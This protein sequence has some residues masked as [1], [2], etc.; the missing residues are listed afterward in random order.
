[1]RKG[2][3]E[4]VDSIDDDIFDFEF[5]DL[6]GADSEGPNEESASEDEVIELVDVVEEG[7]VL[8]D[9]DEDSELDDL[10]ITMESGEIREDEADDL[11]IAMES[12]NLFDETSDDDSE[13]LITAMESDDFL[14][15][16][17]EEEPELTIDDDST[18][19][20]SLEG[21][22]LSEEPE[23]DL[24]ES[25][26]E[27]LAEVE[28]NEDSILKLEDLVEPEDIEVVEADQEDDR[29]EEEDSSLSFGF[30]SRC[31]P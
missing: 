4:E 29:L 26:L 23:L 16:L 31:P 25:D 5:D 20:T 30:R 7:D 28:G 1:M 12:G 9:L 21:L 10:T 19:E 18:S 11:T 24:E 13:D 2:F 27:S 17:D 22:E 14:D 8:G 15:E 3:L 6:P